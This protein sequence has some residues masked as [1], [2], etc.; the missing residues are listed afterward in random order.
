MPSLTVKNIPP[1]LLRTL[2]SLA[3][4][5]NRSLDEQVLALLEEAAEDRLSALRQIEAGWHEQSRRPEPGEID[6]WIQTGSL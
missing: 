6:A 2:K 4:H 5:H 1:R 3:R